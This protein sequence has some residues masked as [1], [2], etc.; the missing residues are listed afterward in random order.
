MT[1]KITQK[2]LDRADKFLNCF[3]YDLI[4]LQVQKD[5]DDARGQGEILWSGEKG[6]SVTTYTGALA[7]QP[8]ISDL[9]ILNRQGFSVWFMVNEGDGVVHEPHDTPRSNRSVTHLT[10]CFIDTDS[11]SLKKALSWCK[12]RAIDPSIIVNTSPGK[13][14]VYFLL[15]KE[16]RTD[17]TA[18]KW[19]AIQR[20]FLSID[21]NYDQAMTDIARVLRVPFFY[22]NKKEPHHITAKGE[23]RRY[24]LDDLYEL[25]GAAKYV[26]TSN[27]FTY[28]EAQVSEGQRHPTLLK[29]LRSLS[30]TLEDPKLLMDAAMGFCLNNFQNPKPFL[31]GGSRHHEIE[32][33]VSSI[34]RYAE[35]EKVEKLASDF[36][37]AK[38]KAET[39]NE[40]FHLPDQF[41]FDCPNSIGEMVKE[42]SN[43]ANYPCAPIDFTGF[44]AF[45]GM[46]KSHLYLTSLGH[47]PANYFLNIAPSGRGKNHIQNVLSQLA[48]S[49]YLTR[50]VEFDLTSDKGLYRALAESDARLFGMCD[51]MEEK[52]K[53]A[54]SNKVRSE[55]YQRGMKTALL[56]VYSSTSRPFKSAKTGNTREKQ[57]EIM[58][59]HLNL[60][61]FGTE[62]TLTNGFS[63]ASIKDGFL[64]R[65]IIVTADG[66]RARN[67]NADPKYKLS[68]AHVQFIRSVALKG[69]LKR[70]QEMK[71]LM[72]M[73][74]ELEDTDSPSRRKEL[75]GEIEELEKK[76]SYTQLK[77]TTIKFTS[78]AEAHYKAF[79]DDM[80]REHNQELKR[81]SGLAELHTRAAEQVGRLCA[82]VANGEVKS[83][84]VEYFVT[85]IRSRVE[86][87]KVLVGREGG[88]LS[89][90]SSQWFDQKLHGQFMMYLRKK[91]KKRN[92]YKITRR[93]L[94]R[95]FQR[96]AGTMDRLIRYCL[97]AGYLEETKG[98]QRGPKS[99]AYRFLGEN[100]AEV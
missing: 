61:M 79:Q 94:F 23:R 92:A 90:G 30:N 11:G 77:A 18:T 3:R 55:G 42:C 1:L 58:N 69:N 84:L 56:R 73:R 72:E 17:E 85:F 6:S 54:T 82:V 49:L 15:E 25:T 38:R 60:C 13:Y 7:D 71:D 5:R 46:V 80:D 50:N 27:E 96:D 12:K 63:T 99:V 37:E 40:S 97:E 87:M 14:H 88:N 28:P 74:Q 45:M 52:L 91:C 20:C 95:G 2:D 29:Y 51:E 89:D 35:K 64:P 9:K 21:P 22:H 47:A 19:E 41:Y 34:I 8:F 66:E 43:A 76:T 78:K 48:F 10:A 70:E 44:L 75:K 98:S 39:Q 4:T 68:D 86:A 33:N 36:K 24:T 83:D 53:S 65:M 16:E 100:D 26:R 93:D 31:P 57:F 62:T 59:P 32:H 67:E 81:G